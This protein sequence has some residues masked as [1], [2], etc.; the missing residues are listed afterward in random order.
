MGK[1]RVA[2]K[3]AWAMTREEL[4]GSNL[5]LASSVILTGVTSYASYRVLG[6]L[7]RDFPGD[8]LVPA[9]VGPIGFALVFAVLLAF[10][11]IFRAPYKMLDNQ[12]ER[13]DALERRLQPA[14]SIPPQEERPPE[15]ILYGDVSRT[16][17]G[18][19]YTIA[20]QTN[21]V[22]DIPIFNPTAVTLRG[23]EAYLATFKDANSGEPRV[24]ESIQLCWL[25][26]ADKHSV[27][28][29]PS[30]GKRSLCVFKCMNNHVALVTDKVPVR[31]VH[32]IEPKGV[33]E[34]V[35]VITAHDTAATRIP[36]R[37][38]CDAPEN[39]PTL[40]VGEIV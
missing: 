25:P 23:C 31:V 35:I 15:T 11:F 30:Q 7:G 3:L 6:A 26:I 12:D 36:F 27:V 5:R 1:R 33:Y 2:F 20:H 37:L 21:D 29:I 17:G 8:E 9:F 4:V 18:Q 28:D 39:P 32:M 22:F 10:N 14:F 19:V 13:L 16:W 40:T 34:G 38:T 24:W